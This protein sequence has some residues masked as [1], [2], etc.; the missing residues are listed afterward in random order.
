MDHK[1]L[2]PKSHTE[3]RAGVGLLK[4]VHCGRPN[5]HKSQEDVGEMAL[6]GISGGS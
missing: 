4:S 5:E 6:S 2:I 3:V 1:I